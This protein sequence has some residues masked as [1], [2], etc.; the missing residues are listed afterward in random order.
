MIRKLFSVLL[1]VALLLPASANAQSAAISNGLNWLKSIQ[2]PD[3]SW[4]N[5]Q[6]SSTDYY[7]AITVLDSFV[8]LGD[9]SL[10]YSN[11]LTWLKS[12]TADTTTYLAPRIKLVAATGDTTTDL[13]TLLSYANSGSGWGG[14]LNQASSTFHTALALQALKAANYTDLTII[15]SALAYLTGTQNSDGGWGFIKGVD[16]T[17]YLTAIVSGTL[18]QFPQMTPIATAVNNATGY[19]LAKQ[20]PD[21]SF[22]TEPTVYD[23]ALALI[24]LLGNG[25]TGAVQAAAMQ[26]AMNYLTTAQT[27]NGSWNDDPYSTALAIRALYLYEN[28]PAP[29]PPPPAGGRITGTVID[30]I[31]GLK[32]SGVAVVLDSNNLIN[33]TTDA[34]G[35]FTLADIPAGSQK[36]N[37]SV[38]G[39][40]ATTATATVVVDTTANLGTIPMTS[41]ATTGVIAGTIT[42]STGKPLTGVA[43]TVTG[44][45]SG[46]ATTGADGTYSFSYVTPGTVTI[47]AVKTGFQTVTA[48]GTVYARTTLTF[49]PRM[50]TTASQVT[51]GTLVG[52][53]VDSYWGVPM[54]HLPE[55]KGVRVIV[56]GLAEVPVEPEG[57]GYFSIPNLA[58]GTYQVI[59]GMHGFKLH[60]FRIVIL[61]GVTTDLGT[62]RL[63]MS[64]LM[65]LTGKI[66]DASTGAP[67]PAAE[68]TIQGKDFIGRTDASG[69]YA[70]ADIPNPGEYTVKFTADGYVGKSFTMGSSAWLQTMDIS[71]SKRVTTGSLT[72]TVIDAAT[73]LPLAGV[74]VTL[75]S[76][77]AV[78]ATTDSNG[79]FT[80]NSIPPGLQRFTLSLN[81]YTSRTLSTVIRVGVVGNA[82]KLPLGVTELPASIQ[83]TAQKV[84]TNTPFAGVTI[85]TIGDVPLQ[86]VT[87][88]DGTYMLDAVPAG[89]VT[90]TANALNNPGFSNARFNSILE[91]GGI[92]VFNPALSMTLPGTFDLT[93]QP[94]KAVH[95]L[96]DTVGIAINLRNRE[97]EAI[98]A[99][100][101]VLVT[102]PHGTS[103]YETSANV[104]IDADG[105]TDQPQSLILPTTA[106]IGRYVVLTEV[107]DA[108]GALLG[109]SYKY[110]DVTVSQI[111]VT[112]VLPAA[113]AAGDNALLFNLVNSGTLAVSA[114]TFSVTLKDPD[115]Q[116]VSTTTQNFILALGGNKTIAATISI[117]SLKFGTYTLSFI[118][119]DETK[120]GQATDIALPNSLAI[121]ALYDDASH[122][123]RGA[124]NLTVTL[125]NTGR[126]DL[127]SASVMSAMPDAAYSETKAL[128]A[129]A[130]GNSSALLYQFTIPETMTAGQHGTRITVTLPSG[131]TTAQ[132]AQ[133]AI[134]ESSLY[135]SPL[136]TTFTAGET[137]QPIIANSGGVDT[138][139]QYHLS[140]YDAKAALIAETT[141]TGTATAGASLSLALAIPAGAVDGSYNLAVTYKDTKTGKEA[142]VP[143]GIT[144]NGVKGSLQVQTDKQN[145]LLTESIT[146]LSSMTS[147]G[148]PLTGGNLH[149]QVTTG[150]GAQKM[151]TWTTQSDFQTGVRNGVDT[152]GVN[153][154]I[155]PDDDFDGA[156]IDKGKWLE[157]N[158]N[159][160]SQKLE[161]GYLKQTAGPGAGF[162]SLLGNSYPLFQ[163]DL[164]IQADFNLINPSSEGESWAIFRIEAPGQEFRVL[165]LTANAMNV[166]YASYW[167][168]SSWLLS[169]FF[170]TTD[171]SGKLR[172]T[173]NGT[174]ATAYNWENGAW[175]ALWSTNIWDGPSNVRFWTTNNNNN[176]YVEVHW[177]NFKVNS[178]QIVTKNESVDSVRLLPLNDNFDDS[179]INYDR[180][181]TWTSEGSASEIN[182][183]L[184]LKT[185]ENKTAYQYADAGLKGRWI[186]GDFDIQI[187][188]TNNDL[189][190]S[191]WLYAFSVGFLPGDGIK[192]AYHWYNTA[193]GVKRYSA[194]YRDPSGLH[195]VTLSS[196][197]TSDNFGKLRLKRVGDTLTWFYWNNSLNRW[198]WNGNTSGVSMKAPTTPVLVTLENVQI[199]N[200]NT[201]SSIS[202][203]N[204]LVASQTYP[205]S[206]ILQL[207]YDSGTSGNRWSKLIHSST[208]PVGTSIKF[209]TR[210]AE[211]ETGLAT[212]IW[213][214]YLAASG[215]AV[216]SSAARW[217][218]IES[219]LSTTNTNVTPL[220]H[221][222][223]V[224]Y[225]T[226]SGEILWQADVPA[227]LAE[228]VVT[229]V[230]KSIGTLG[231]TGKF[232]LEGTLTSSTGQTVAAASYPF[233]V[234]LGNIQM[235]LALDKKIYRPGETVTITSE[236]KNLSSIAATGLTVRVQ[237][238]GV[239]TPYTETFD[240]PANSSR[241]F[242]FTTTAGNN[243][244]YQLDGSVTQNLIP[245]ADIADQYEVASPTL[246]ATLAAPDAAGNEPF[247][248]SLSLTNSGKVTA[249]TTVH[250]VDD[251]GTVVGDQSVTLAA[252]ESRILNYTRQING[253]TTYTA[254][255]SGDLN[256]TVT[257]KVAYAVVATD[258][259][260]SGKIVTDKASYN[261]NEQV[262][263]TTTLSAASMRENLS[264]LITVTNNQGQALYSAT[265]AI[266]S[267]IQG[268]AVTNRNYWNTGSYPAG[269]YL[270][271]LQIQGPTG[272]VIAKTTCN[273]TINSSFKPS[274][275]L[276]G[277][278]SL[279]KQSLLTGEI[280]TAS[281]SVTN[282]GNVDLAGVPLSIR[283]VNLAEQTTYDTIAD[284]AN[285]AMGATY[286]KNGGID[287]RNYSAKDYLVVLRATIGGVEETLAGSYFR[288]EGAPSAP[289]LI[290][291]ANGSD[292]DTLTPAL[293]VSNAADPNDDKLTYEFE[294]YSDSGL[295]NLVLSATTPET[296][297]ATT[298][299]VPAPLT[300]NQTYSWRARAYDGRLYGPWMTPATFRVNTINDPPTA[301]TV[302][303]P[304]EGTSVASLVPVLTVGNTTDPDSTNLTYNFDVALDPD[305]TRIVATTKGV[306]SGQGTTSWTVP[307]NLQENG[308]YYWRAQADDWLMEGPWSSTARFI[309]NTTNDAPTAPVVMSPANGSTV[310]VLSTDVVVT[311]SS[312]PDSISLLYYFEADTVPTF[313]STGIIRSGGITEG[314][315][316]TL[317][318]LS[319]LQDNI[320]YYLRVKGSDGS[321]DSPWS[322]VTGFFANTFNDPPTTPTL[323][324]P[325]NGAGVSLFTPT[326]TVHNAADLDMDILT[327]EF[328][329]YSDAVLTT[330][331]TQSGAVAETA[332]VTGWTVPVALAENQTYYWRARAGD[333]S[334]QS[335]WMPTAAF[336]INTAND[337]PGAPQ[338][339]APAE[340]TTLSTLTPALEV[341]NAL[342]PDSSAL[343]YDFEL[344][345]NSLLVASVNAVPENVS[346]KTSATLSSALADNTS[347]TWRVRAFDG[348]RYGQ[349]MNMATFKTHISATNI[350]AEIRFEPVTLNKK[351][352][353]NWVMVQ[354][355]LP[356]GYLA[357]DVD[358]SSLRLEG[359]V[360]AEASPVSISKRGNAEVLTVKFLRSAAIA[361][362]PSGDSVPVHVT[363]KIGLALFEG[364]DVIRVVK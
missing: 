352:A 119:S 238:T 108:T 44:A 7:T 228:N 204:L 126:F 172:I 64:F 254:V 175:R 194:V 53:V 125:R 73:S 62:I 325:S 1:L 222:V 95:G 39:F 227:S 217:I 232:Y 275:L 255:M 122:R 14:Y 268:Q 55:E 206:G 114:G 151:K 192:T 133:L 301:P 247:S 184:Q 239:A 159:T 76:D 82:G 5:S 218:E 33:T 109:N 280:V 87:A 287:T 230:N 246:S 89:T 127:G 98:V 309:V 360:P 201:S 211:T 237:G 263:L 262:M 284:Q 224:T 100:L 24:T 288:V 52:R 355:E 245:L 45:W 332:S 185:T 244:I 326:L 19:L 169:G 220:L 229:D 81:G 16:S 17:V 330:L 363:G 103:V 343:T 34:S 174:T 321:A 277:K 123:I 6:S 303:S 32:V 312:D 346:G 235:L 265:T 293:T 207:K 292:V 242:S 179:L 75:A 58:P 297:G 257:K 132:T 93:V 310:S 315:G 162:A 68:V 137:I 158:Y 221:D 176:N 274:A 298:W 289:A 80:L 130:V 202:W 260:V 163:S 117:P 96:G 8:T 248:I 99:L 357:A 226:N 272:A 31:T 67:I 51:T 304:A 11:G 161:N 187:D 348:D 110:F 3:G 4:S 350:R 354:I 193:F 148:T 351:S 233:Y 115:G 152:Y 267:I 180:L 166:Y 97:A 276:K 105:A 30:K 278:L 223:S 71:L 349:W 43:I 305:F 120:P 264:T 111:S 231:M 340:G 327:Y 335:G 38:I 215:S 41:A 78:T 124:A 56:P 113:F 102:D 104:T 72:G 294:I 12:A 86:T 252:G 65:T 336:M 178:G 213:S 311:N 171:T 28:R 177:D 256:Q 324:N 136:Q 319:G 195:D 359:A 299:T 147:T 139:V 361:L 40:A 322:P 70:I 270:V 240:L 121:T 286:T 2:A 197:P 156:V 253:T 54:G 48:S 83:G 22:G 21:G 167:N 318:H 291:P 251:S 200:V 50:S 353:G 157:E 91:P 341:L 259:S 23:T 128:T 317:W 129:L 170:S 344:Y 313:D 338:L 189:V 9:T 306:A 143:N 155:I 94:D 307:I 320:R 15:N 20:N 364:V 234:E 219:T 199:A 150:P 79:V 296:T 66:T 154:W 90:V 10:A 266:P 106:K 165:R 283:T 134:M 269:T 131:S 116:V 345:G 236:V 88:A 281:Y 112:P 358:I 328:E 84:G 191:G 85:R 316:T 69:T 149:L 181:S 183:A 295:A 203:N 168:G 334:L 25:E 339:S 18:Q 314:Q 142:T 250:V 138:P 92:L 258:S 362:L 182:G 308:W 331:V 59:V 210:T 27:S 60:T 42:D 46:N 302:S 271:T 337:T 196:V 141:N 279:D 333:G 209:R 208:K 77:S 300:E 186:E 329:I 173:K 290:G 214:G 212:A 61:P 146:G 342:D 261:P 47:S 26:N 36:V 188:F 29:P 225:E 63:E 135:L 198:E 118:Q 107:F 101:H 74:A 347:Y 37:F 153:D 273:L 243:G 144:I 35:N 164:D 145:Y 49:S 356:Q 190:G 285:L 282:V 160:N 249:S 13:N 205:S 140:L 216:T 323:A 241:P 57:G